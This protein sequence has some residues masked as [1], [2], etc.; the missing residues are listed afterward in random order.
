MLGWDKG[1][2]AGFDEL[3]YRNVSGHGIVW[4]PCSS[5]SEHFSSCSKCSKHLVHEILKDSGSELLGLLFPLVYA[6]CLFLPLMFCMALPRACAWGC[7]AMF[8]RS[9][10]C[11]GAWWGHVTGLFLV[12]LVQVLWIAL[13]VGIIVLS[14]FFV[15]DIEIEVGKRSTAVVSV[16]CSTAGTV[17]RN[18]KTLKECDDSCVLGGQGAVECSNVDMD[19]MCWL[20]LS[21][22]ACDEEGSLCK[23]QHSWGFGAAM[24]SG[25]ILIIS[26][27]LLAY[28]LWRTYQDEE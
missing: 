13:G 10:K 28:L 23:L 17:C 2:V 9:W 21:H 12:M 14:I 6:F 22:K 8:G 27:V 15:R 26:A 4:A 18:V 20:E 25:S 11:D 7:V 1:C 16:V 19:D 24:S 5:N 3:K